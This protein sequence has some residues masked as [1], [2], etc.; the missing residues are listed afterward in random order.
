METLLCRRVELARASGK[1]L[2]EAEPSIQRHLEHCEHC[3]EMIAMDNAIRDSLRSN[4]SQLRPSSRRR[5]TNTVLS[6]GRSKRSAA[7][8]TLA[9]WMLVAVAS[10]LLVVMVIGIKSMHAVQPT[11]DVQAVSLNSGEPFAGIA[12]IVAQHMGKPVS[13][14]AYSE[15][16]A[17]V[18]R[19]RMPVSLVNRL[20]MKHSGKDEVDLVGYPTNMVM[21]DASLF[22]LDKSKVPI[23]PAFDTALKTS[24][25]LTL[26]WGPHQVT[27]SASNSHLFVIVASSDGIMTAGR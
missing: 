5:I 3:H 6:Y 9:Q 13:T 2:S 22:V 26:G 16:D 7:G 20:V 19:G 10:S 14:D 21:R 15:L 24:S 4:R 8:S 18:Y 23:D 25:G 11:E 17:L 27:V 12:T 1:L